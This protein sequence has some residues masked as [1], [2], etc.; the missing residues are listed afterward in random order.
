MATRV[1]KVGKRTS[2]P[3]Q[4][5]SGAEQSGPSCCQRIQRSALNPGQEAHSELR[6]PRTCLSIRDANVIRLPTNA[7]RRG[8]MYR[9]ICPIYMKRDYGSEHDRGGL[10]LGG[11]GQPNEPAP[12]REFDRPK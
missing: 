8:Y 1:V 9:C 10:F 12:R 3:P 2:E 7:K 5:G 6:S 4:I 11:D